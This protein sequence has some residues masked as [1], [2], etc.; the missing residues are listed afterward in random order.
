M[1]A[2]RAPSCLVQHR[3]IKCVTLMG[4][5]RSQRWEMNGSGEV[6]TNRDAVSHV[7]LCAG[8]APPRD[9]T[10]CDEGVKYLFLH[11]TPTEF[12]E[13]WDGHIGVNG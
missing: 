10:Q 4:R 9:F 13:P 3:E 8:H 6:R 2:A 5:L 11:G 12:S 1:T 7:H